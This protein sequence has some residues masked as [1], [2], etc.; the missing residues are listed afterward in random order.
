MFGPS[1]RILLFC[2]LLLTFPFLNPAGADQNLIRNLERAKGATVGILHFGVTDP[3]QTRFSI[4]GT[5]VHIGKGYLITA[6][7]AV[8][9]TKRGKDIISGTLT[10]LTEE[11]HEL[12]ATLIGV[13]DFVDIA[14]YR[15][16]PIPD[17]TI[18]KEVSFAT[19]NA[20]LGDEVVTVGYPLGWGP[21]FAFG[22]MGNPN[23]FLP[24]VQSRL[25]QVDL[26][27]CSGNSGG[28]LFS[29]QG[30]LIG[31][32]H[33]IIQTQTGQDE[34]LCSRFAFVIPGG[35]V[36][37]IVQA[38]IEGRHPR[39]S[40]LGLQMTVNKIGTQ[41]RVAVGQAKGPA[42]RAGLRKGDVILSINET[43]ITSPA[44][45]KNYVIEQTNPGQIIKIHILRDEEKKT[46]DVTLGGS[47]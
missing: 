38:F 26:S 22:R 31:I 21:A 29:L 45:L 10:L 12:T 24:T 18:L 4:R 34:R 43:R 23:T 1:I 36:Q 14:L 30:E 13:N 42:E 41:W 39:F 25:M 8:E 7:H 20:S 35:L 47:S 5:G 28:G 19:K 32:V 2:Q 17:S 46:I 3:D 44:Q 37:H 9:E 15:I 40:T 11:L 27:A 33:A 6:R 16:Y